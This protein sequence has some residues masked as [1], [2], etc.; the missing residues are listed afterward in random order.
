MIV[1][2]NL[3]VFQKQDIQTAITVFEK[4]Y[5]R[6]FKKTP[7]KTTNLNGTKDFSKVAGPLTNLTKKQ[8]K[9]I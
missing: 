8:G 5:T 1:F 2:E 9:F 6:F 7:P 3:F 4:L